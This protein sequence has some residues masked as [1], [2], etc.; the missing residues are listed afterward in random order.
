MAEGTRD[1]CGVPYIRA[2]MPFVRAPPS[3][4][5]GLSEAPLPNTITGE[6]RIS[7]CE[8]GGECVEAQIFS[9]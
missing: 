9:P 3:R 6:V 8:F 1:L 2:L 5:N 4:P 7:T